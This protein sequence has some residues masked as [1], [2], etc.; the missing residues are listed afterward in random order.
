MLDELI[1]E[2]RKELASVNAK[3]EVIRQQRGYVPPAFIAHGTHVSPDEFKEAIGCNL[4]AD[5][6][7]LPKFTK[8]TQN[9]LNVIRGFR[10]KHPEIKALSDEELQ[11]ALQI[12][13][14]AFGLTTKTDDN[15]QVV[16]DD[17]GYP[18]PA[19]GTFA[20]SLKKCSARINFTTEGLPLLI[21]FEEKYKNFEQGENVGHIYIVNGSS[22]KAE[23][24]D[25]HNITEYTSNENLSVVR[26]LEVTP[27]EAMAHNAQIVVFNSEKDYDAWRSALTGKFE[28][29][30]SNNS[31]QMRSLAE[32]I[33]S[34]SATYINASSRGINPRIPTLTA[35]ETGRK[36][37]KM[38]L[39]QHFYGRR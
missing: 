30:L 24:N 15:N 27:K 10:E 14:R 13:Q 19:D 33:R 7:I 29:F 20:Y 18:I 28:L 12:P 38:M 35:A 1:E 39:M 37:A 6:M 23:Y 36:A 21:G 26:H 32:A 3:Q 11:K 31:P 8:E 16:L 17:A 34:G 4:P 25:N 22:F 9:E 2:C 5:E